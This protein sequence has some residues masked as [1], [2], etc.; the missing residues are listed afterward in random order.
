MLSEFLDLFF[1]NLPF[2]TAIT[3]LLGCIYC[4][5]LTS[6]HGK[7]QSVEL[8]I[9]MGFASA[10]FPTGIAII[11]SAFNPHYIVYLSDIKTHLVIFGFVVL[12]LAMKTA[13]SLVLRAKTLN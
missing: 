11:I 3:A 4:T 7:E 2:L 8:I 12:I 10:A 5:V 6:Y 13:S 1:N 9:N